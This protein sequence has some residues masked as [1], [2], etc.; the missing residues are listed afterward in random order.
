MISTTGIAKKSK[1]KKVATQKKEVTL[2]NIDL[3]ESYNK[4]KTYNGQ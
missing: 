3:S 2:K 4:F 1:R